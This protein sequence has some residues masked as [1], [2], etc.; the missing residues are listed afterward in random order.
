MRRFPAQV[1]LVLGVVLFCCS[2]FG[3][4]AKPRATTFRLDSLEGLE[5]INIK[6][7]VAEYRGRRAVRLLR[8]DDAGAEANAENESLAILKGTD[9]KDGIIEA[10]VAGMPGAKA[11]ADARGFIGIAF[12][13][14][15][16]GEKFEC[17]YLRPTNGRADDQ[18][19]RNH[20]VQYISFPD[21]HFK[22]LRTENPGVYESYADLE[23][24]VWTKIKI[25]VAGRKA[26][27]YVNGAEQ[28]C[29]IVNDLKLGDSRG[30]IALWTTSE[31]DGYFSNLTVK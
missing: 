30:Q 21:Y 1:F 3:R 7:E 23:T 11:P 17:F 18:L 5:I 31:T 26:K 8:R 6:A 29:L 10:E 28:P 2:A 15:E 20:S 16:H 24:G 25:E 27:L 14:A 13:V 22:R 19:R 12:R 9:F 4:D